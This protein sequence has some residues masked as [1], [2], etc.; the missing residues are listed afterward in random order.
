MGGA[1]GDEQMNVVTHSANRM[2]FCTQ[3]LHHA[4][5]IFMDT[6]TKS[7]SQPRLAVFGAEDDMIMEA[8]V[9]GH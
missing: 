3:T 4:S 1:Q 2:N 6:D 7:G 5:N 8:K 9:S